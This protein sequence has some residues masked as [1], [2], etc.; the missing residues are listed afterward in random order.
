MVFAILRRAAGSLFRHYMRNQRPR[1][2]RTTISRWSLRLLANQSE[3]LSLSLCC[4]VATPNSVL[5]SSHN[6]KIREECNLRSLIVRFSDILHVPRSFKYRL[7]ILLSSSVRIPGILT[8][9]TGTSRYSR[10]TPATSGSTR[11]GPRDNPIE[12]LSTA[13]LSWCRIY[14]KRLEPP[15]HL[16]RSPSLHSLSSSAATSRST[17]STVSPR[18]IAPV[19]SAV[20]TACPYCRGAASE[21]VTGNWV[22]RLGTCGQQDMNLR[23]TSTPRLLPG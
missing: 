12:T 22:E 21:V 2:G 23:L 4:G 8:R 11:D 19:C 7:P 16:Q 13:H 20:L 1:F 5:Y 17:T 10:W 6:V 9:V 15:T 14:D 18:F 3:E